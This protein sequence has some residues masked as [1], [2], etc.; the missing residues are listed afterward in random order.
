MKENDLLTLYELQTSWARARREV[1]RQRLVC[2]I[3]HCPFDLIPFEEVR[4]R[5]HL[6]QRICRGL[7]EIDLEHIRGSVG[8]YRDFTSAFLPRRGH[9]RQRWERVNQFIS[10]QGMLPIEVYQVGKT[11]FVVD[12]NHR[13]SVARQMGLKMIEAHVCEFVTPLAPGADTN[14]NELTVSLNGESA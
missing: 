6:A 14:L 5:L 9:L 1:F 13:V 8:R 10:T 4:R 3:K 7:Q 11:Y 2:A 12:G